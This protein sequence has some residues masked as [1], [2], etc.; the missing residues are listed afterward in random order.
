MLVFVYVCLSA[1][2]LACVGVHVD[3]S[4]IM[5]LNFPEGLLTFSCTVTACRGGCRDQLAHKTENEL[6]LCFKHPTHGPEAN[7]WFRI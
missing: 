5:C 3:V 1:S 7:S 4:V 6:Q 2:V